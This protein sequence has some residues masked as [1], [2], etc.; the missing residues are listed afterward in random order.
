M[1]PLAAMKL[2]CKPAPMPD[3]SS[4][5]RP[6]D[7]N[8]PGKLIVDI[9]VDEVEDPRV[10]HE[11]DPAAVALGSLGGRKG[12]SARAAKLFAEQRREIAQKAAQTRWHG[13]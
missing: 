11:K 13:K 9:S 12:G 7:I 8:Q 3:R 5:G 4:S 1:A 6:R 10:K 2:A